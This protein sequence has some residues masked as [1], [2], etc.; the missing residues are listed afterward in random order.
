[1]GR[2]NAQAVSFDR[3][4]RIHAYSRGSSST[5]SSV[6]TGS[7]QQRQSDR[8]FPGVT[9][10]LFCCGQIDDVVDASVVHGLCG[11]WGMVAT[12]L[13]TTKLGYARAYAE[14]RTHNQHGLYCTFSCR[15]N[16]VLAAF[17]VGARRGEA[18]WMRWLLYD[19]ADV[20]FLSSLAPE[21]GAQSD[22]TQARRYIGFGTFEC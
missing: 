1:M 6:L 15:P 2:A 10:R 22:A 5:S 17:G 9:S 4:A 14:V 19:R 12:G 20:F 18:C 8:S 11:L 3:K 13:F 21:S 16:G 7:G